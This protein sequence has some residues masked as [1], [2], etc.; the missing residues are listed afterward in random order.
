MWFWLLGPLRVVH[1]D[2]TEAALGGDKQR[3][4]LVALLL[5]S[6]RAVPPERLIDTLWPDAAPVS[7]RSSLHNLVSGL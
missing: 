6:G 7:A 4:L 3:M 1:D 5:E 2:G